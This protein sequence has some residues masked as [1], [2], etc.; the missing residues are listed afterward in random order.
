MGRLIVVLLLFSLAAGPAIAA[1]ATTRMSVQP[2]GQMAAVDTTPPVIVIT[3]PE[4]QR[5]VKI[6]AREASVTVTGRA[7]DDSGVAS[8]TVNGQPAALDEN[9]NFSAEVLL[10]IGENQIS[11]SAEDIYKNIATE[12]F[13]MVR[14]AGTV[15]V[16]RQETQAPA[17]TK[18]KNYAL[19]IGINTYENIPPLKTAVNGARE[20]GKVLREEYGFEVRSILDA[21]ATRTAIMKEL[22]DLKNRLNPEDRLLIYYAG[23]GYNDTET[24]TSYWLPVEADKDDPTNWI[25][26]RSITDQLKRTRAKQVL[27]VADSC[28]SGTM[29]RAVDPSLSGRGSRESY[30]RRLMDKPSRVLIASGGNEPVTDTGGKRHSIFAQVFIDAL[31]DA[32]DG[33]F[34]AEELLTRQIKE[35]VAGRAEQTPEYKIIRNSGHDGGDFVFVRVK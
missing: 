19:I 12:R 20:V 18:G 27:I 11:V 30:L 31:K 16:A 35:S 14:Q 7:T 23:H 33:I 17:P 21:K 15:V 26:A 28:Y 5:G 13:T 9:G 25:E 34:T 24:E 3:S 29:A 8:V 6:T 10:K 1:T 32:P 22:N 4:V 2:R